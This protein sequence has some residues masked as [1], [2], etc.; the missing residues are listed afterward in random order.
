MKILARW[1]TIL[2]SLSVGALAVSVGAFSVLDKRSEA[3]VTWAVI[4]LAASVALLAAAWI[5]DRGEK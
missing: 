2:L 3:A 5:Y 1:R 4:V